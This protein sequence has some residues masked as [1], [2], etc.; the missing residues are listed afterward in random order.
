MGIMYL[1]VPPI[2]VRLPLCLS[3]SYFNA[4]LIYK[5]TRRP[6][7]PMANPKPVPAVAAAPGLPVELPPLAL[8]FSPL[9]VVEG[10]VVVV[11]LELALEL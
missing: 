8:W 2:Y 9:P 3:L 10:P 6:A 4:P 7:T 11:M 1:R 5:A